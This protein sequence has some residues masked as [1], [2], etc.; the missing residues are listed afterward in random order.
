[1]A[2]NPAA[3]FRYGSALIAQRG[4]PCQ[5]P[6]LAPL[7][8]GWLSTKTSESQQRPGSSYGKQDTL[9]DKN[10]RLAGF[11]RWEAALDDTAAV[12]SCS[13]RVKVTASLRD[14]TMGP[15]RN[16]HRTPVWRL[17][18]TALVSIVPV[19]GYASV[20]A[21]TAVPRG[22]GFSVERETPCKFRYALVKI[23]TACSR[24]QS[25]ANTLSPVGKALDERPTF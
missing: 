13:S 24:N 5:M 17:D 23:T 25:L 20:C 7:S 21:R 14:A 15:E 3:T 22:G 18:F 10:T 8:S 4:L 16:L 6:V 11:L 12:A 2:V 1:M 9:R 19:R